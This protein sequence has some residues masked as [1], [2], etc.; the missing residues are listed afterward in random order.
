M[1][2]ATMQNASI[3]VYPNPDQF[4]T[5]LAGPADQP[6]VMLNLIRFKE[7]ADAPDEGLSGEIAYRRYLEA[8][9]PFIL[10]RGARVIWSGRFDCQMLGTGAEGF[11]FMALVEYPSRQAFLAIATDPEVQRFSVHR[12]A[13]LEG[14]WLLAAT[15]QR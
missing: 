15:T 9:E 3:A 2:Y 14:Q 13:G 8:M 5:L 1:H 7:R 6:V 10:Q 12:T 11:H 4:T